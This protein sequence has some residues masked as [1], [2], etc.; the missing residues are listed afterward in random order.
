VKLSCS[1]KTET[2]KK[3][4]ALPAGLDVLLMPGVA[5]EPATGARLGRGG[6]YYDAWAGRAGCGR[7]GGD[8][9]GKGGCGSV[10]APSTGRRPT[11][12]TPTTRP[13]LLVA[14]A[15]RCQVVEGVPAGG[16]DVA[17]DAVATADGL[18]PCSARGRAALA[19]G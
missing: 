5:F 14:L 15:F 16:G 3:L 17:V 9:G 13:P 11:P 8:G 2:T 4:T 12:T 10:D 6:G 19:G 1:H 18:V 7:S